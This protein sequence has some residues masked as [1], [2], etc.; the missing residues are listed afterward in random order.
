MHQHGYL[1]LYANDYSYCII[2]RAWVRSR[3]NLWT[4]I[5]AHMVG[6][7]MKCPHCHKYF[8]DETIHDCP[9]TA[10]KQRIKQLEQDIA[11]FEIHAPLSYQAFLARQKLSCLAY[12]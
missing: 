8:E 2:P 9:I 5:S 12:Q 3:T 6:Q 10:L 4:F 1:T 11:W 7:K